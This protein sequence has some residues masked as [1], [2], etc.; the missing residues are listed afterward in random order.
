M[1]YPLLPQKPILPEYKQSYSRPYDITTRRFFDEPKESQ[2]DD[3]STIQMIP[4][5]IQKTVFHIT[6]AHDT[7]YYRMRY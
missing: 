6:T 2:A 4:L 1:T 7:P 3:M 5:N